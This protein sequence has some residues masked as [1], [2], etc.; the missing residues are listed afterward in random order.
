MKIY[1]F[2]PGPACLSNSALNAAGEAAKEYNNS[3]MSILEMSHRS[4]EVVS[5]FEEGTANHIH[6]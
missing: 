3:G 1:N 6:I 4:K 5:L 2:S